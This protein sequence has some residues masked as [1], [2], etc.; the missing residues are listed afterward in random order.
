MATYKGIQGYSVQKLSDDPTASS[1]TEGQLWYNSG[2]GKFKIVVAGAA[3]WASGNNMNTARSGTTGAGIQ[4]AA[5]IAAGS[6]GP[7]SVAL[8]EQYDGSTWSEK[9]D[10]NTLRNETANAGTTAAGLIFGGNAPNEDLTETWNGTS[11]AETSD[12][13]TGRSY[14]G[15][16]GTQTAALAIAGYN[17]GS[18]YITNTESYNGTSWSETGDL[19][20]ATNTI[21]CGGIS[22]SAFAAGGRAGPAVTTTSQTF[23][24][25]SWTTGNSI[26]TARRYGGGNA[27]PGAP[28]AIIFGGTTAGASANVANTETFDGTSWTEV[29]DLAAAKG[30]TVGGGGTNTSGLAFGG[31]NPS[32]TALATTEKWNDPVYTIKT[33]TV[34]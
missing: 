31:F 24:G 18:T 23:N 17:P 19:G 21:M 26:N 14:L 3:A 22:T 32:S 30:G 20:T 5:F 6:T 1:D 25:T 33:V 8:H 7:A 34:S 28:T 10:I 4:T 9:A 16:A 12:L 15:R 13:N 11:W 29:A 2:S 27:V